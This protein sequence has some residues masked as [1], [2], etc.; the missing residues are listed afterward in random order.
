[1]PSSGPQRRVEGPVSGRY[2]S[3][4]ICPTRD[5][6]PA[7]V[8]HLLAIAIL[9]IA[10][11][12]ARRP[13]ADVDA[14]R[15]ATQPDAPE[16]YASSKAFG[17]Y[18][19]SRLAAASG[20]VPRALEEL[21]LA[22]V[23]DETS[24]QLHVALGELL[25]RAGQLDPAE[26]QA[27]RALEL[28]PRGPTSADAHLLLGKVQIAQGK[29]DP[30]IQQLRAAI[31]AQLA[32]KPVDP[33]DPQLNPEPWRLLGRVYL[34]TGD[35]PGAART[36]EDLSKHLPSEGSGFGD[37]GRVYFEKHD[38]AR[39]RTY[40]KKE[41]DRDRLDAD[42]LRRLAEADEGLKRYDDAR[43]DYEALVRLDDEDVDALLAL[44]RLAIQRG[45]LTGARKQFADL[46]RAAP[47]ESAARV[48]VALAW[49]EAKK[50]SEAISVVDEG[51]RTGGDGRLYFVKGLVEQDERRFSDAAASFGKVR[52][53]DGELYESARA[54]MA[55][56]L[57]QLG[58]HAEAER[59]LA[60]PLKAQPNNLKFVTTLAIIRE[61]DGKVNE[62]IELLRRTLGDG[63]RTGLAA[64]KMAELTDA[65]ANSLERAG[66]TK[67]A[68][69]LL[70]K[71][72][73]A[74]PRDEVLLYALGGAYEKSGDSEAAVG[75]MKALLTLDP[76]NADALNFLGYTYAE[77][78]VKLDE[79]EKLVS[80]AVELK[81]EN[82][83]F[84]DS[85]GW[86]FFK[87]GDFGKAIS[88]LEKAN[89]LSGPEAT[90]LEHL[91]DAYR[92]AQRLADAAA[93]YRKAL[94]AV[95]PG[96]PSEEAKQRLGLEKKLK[97]L[98]AADVRPKR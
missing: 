86:V 80:K 79:A 62:A 98:S 39:A 7:S 45:D 87:K 81:P 2:N 25:A 52:P 85:L 93:A 21:R 15:E 26:M 60:A 1:M 30:A 78:G 4:V 18:L 69:A 56:S 91:G 97:E 42:S 53:E 32:S 29:R 24:P 73:E 31:A 88:L 76:D 43:K 63:E 96:T 14:M 90:I 77:R 74:R 35:E 12:A 54:D 5:P 22:L 58:R 70:G 13:V 95:E 38:Y 59:A 6:L 75:Q 16:Q 10:C 47:D 9:G 36:F 72:L 67:E 51:L 64:E 82:G 28:E 92:S 34:E 37:M 89:A 71:A 17:H 41:V 48:S 27:R 65:L 19:R 83:Y 44:G 66:K 94:T 84:L 68:I 61:R 33:G 20:D 46:V 3:R 55:L 8:R 50:N 40:L 11:G 49:I 23:F 57:S